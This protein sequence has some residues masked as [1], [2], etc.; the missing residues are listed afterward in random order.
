MRK[1]LV[2]FLCCLAV[3]ALQCNRKPKPKAAARPRADSVALAERMGNLEFSFPAEALA[4]MSEPQVVAY[5]SAL[6]G[7][8]EVLRAAGFRAP[9]LEG[10]PREVYARLGWLADTMR[11]VPG[12]DSA[13]FQAGLSYPAF[14]SRFTQ[15]WVA[16]YAI[17]LDSTVT[18][19]RSQELDTLPEVRRTLMILGPWIRACSMIPPANKGLARTYRLQLSV[20]GSLL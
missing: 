10:T 12:F 18:A 8:V 9:Y 6:P 2:I 16:G 11:A 7:V 4:P 1:L 19:L 14:R 15:V 3:S 13:L 5:A 17:V 20:L